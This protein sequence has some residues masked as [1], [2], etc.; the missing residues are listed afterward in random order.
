MP[1]MNRK[2]VKAKLK[3]SILMLKEAISSI[4]NFAVKESFFVDDPTL[5]L[6]LSCECDEIIGI[7]ENNGKG[8]L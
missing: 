8:T 1:K 2:Q 7:I 5:I 6:N 3:K 4:N